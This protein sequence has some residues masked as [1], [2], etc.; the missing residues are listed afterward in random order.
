MDYLPTLSEKW[1]HSL[2]GASGLEGCSSTE[3]G[4][5]KMG[6]KLEDDPFEFRLG[7]FWGMKLLPSYI[8]IIS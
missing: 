3:V 6:R 5:E 2:H 7:I 4:P 8:G 1:P